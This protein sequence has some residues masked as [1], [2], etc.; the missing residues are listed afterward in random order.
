MSEA[1]GLTDAML[2]VV[3]QCAEDFATSHGLKI[4]AVMGLLGQA[5]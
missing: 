5:K 3:S 4:S 1:T 2:A